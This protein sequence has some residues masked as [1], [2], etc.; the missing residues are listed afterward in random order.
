MTSFR[1]AVERASRGVHKLLRTG[2]VP[3]ILSSIVLA[4]AGSLFSL[5]YVGAQ[6]CG[7]YSQHTNKTAVSLLFSRVSPLLM[8]ARGR[9][10]F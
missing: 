8:Q 7:S 6:V 9:G 2:E 10:A 1:T 3:A 5:C 4:M